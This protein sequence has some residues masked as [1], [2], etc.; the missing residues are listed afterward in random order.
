VILSNVEDHDL[1]RLGRALHVELHWLFR[2]LIFFLGRTIVGHHGN[3]IF[4]AL[5]IHAFE[6]HLNRSH[7]RRGFSLLDIELENVALIEPLQFLHFAFVV[8]DQS[9]LHAQIAHRG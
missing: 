6:F 1:V 8:R 9:A 4:V 3:R 5:R 2:G 7:A